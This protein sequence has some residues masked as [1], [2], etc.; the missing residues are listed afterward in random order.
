MNFGLG[1]AET[2]QS[3]SALRWQYGTTRLDVLANNRGRG[4]SLEQRYHQRS[5]LFADGYEQ[6]GYGELSGA[7]A[8]HLELLPAVQVASHRHTSPRCVREL[9]DSDDP[10]LPG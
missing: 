5:M 6:C 2:R 3:T 9:I 10:Q 1:L 8:R 7:P 4:L